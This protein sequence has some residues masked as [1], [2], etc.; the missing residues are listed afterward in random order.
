M[1][2]NKKEAIQNLIRRANE[3]ILC[4]P[5]ADLDEQSAVAVGY[6]HLV[7]QFKRLVTP[8]LPPEPASRLNK[9][10]VVDNI[11]SVYAAHAELEALI[12]E[13]KDALAMLDQSGF[14]TH[15]SGF[16]V[17]PS[18]IVTLEGLTTSNYDVASLIRICK[19]IN[20]SYVHGNVLAVVLL[21]RTVLNHVPPVFGCDT[22][23]QVVAGVGKSLKES[24]EHLENGL[25]KI[26]DFHAHRKIV[27]VETYP[28]AAQVEPFKP[29]FELLLQ[30]VEF[31][32]KTQGV[33][34]Q[35]FGG[36]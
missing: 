28:S 27:S 25:R 20:S 6:N 11:Y 12:P 5:S 15:A 2:T 13:I 9:I 4:G 17:E 33:G 26:A 18:L 23:A 30:Q 29:Q 31:R 19:E 14:P 7:V 35:E 1:H 32:L 8:I 36:K 3:F 22:F 16:I 34:K 24:F 10:E 21:M